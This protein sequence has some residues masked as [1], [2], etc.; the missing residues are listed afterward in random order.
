MYTTIY[1]SSFILQTT[2]SSW[3]TNKVEVGRLIL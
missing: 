2:S 3:S 1:T